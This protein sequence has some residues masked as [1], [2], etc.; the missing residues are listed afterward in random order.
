MAEIY[1]MSNVTIDENTVS[2]PEVVDS[3]VGFALCT[4]LL[5]LCY[6]AYLSKLILA[7]PSGSAKMKEIAAA[8]QEGSKAFLVREYTWLAGFVGVVS[9]IML[10][11]ISMTTAIMFLL[12]AVIS[13]TPSDFQLAL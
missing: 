10:L 12:G 1:V 2:G 5:A 6:A 7:A 3:A 4:G 9:V 11:A 13:G 8:I